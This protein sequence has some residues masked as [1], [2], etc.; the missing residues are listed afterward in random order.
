MK[1]KVTGS[2]RVANAED[3]P[4]SVFVVKDNKKNK[5][6]KQKIYKLRYNIKK[7]EVEKHIK[8]EPH[9]MDEVK[10]YIKNV[11]GFTELEPDTDDYQN[12]YMQMRASF[13]MQYAQELLGEYASYPK[14]E[15]ED[16][17][18]VKRF[19]E[20]VELRQKAAE[21]VPKEVFDIDLH[22]FEK[23]EA[24]LQMRFMI[25]ADYGYIGGS[26]SGSKLKRF[27]QIER[28]VYR[29]YGVTQ[30]DIDNKTR[31]YEELVKTL[32]RR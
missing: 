24:D 11:C 13:I 23:K 30:E 15:G 16:E 18:S 5:T 14:L 20:Q 31:R 3:G 12:E 4:T 28:N 1:K 29:Y 32:A 26:A 6:I 9:S 7:A 19:M 8:A 17:E 10:E 22:I 27:E 21:N 25:E 2:F